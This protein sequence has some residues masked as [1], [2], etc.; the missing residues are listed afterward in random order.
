MSTT[1]TRT[2]VY[3]RVT[4]QIVAELEKGHR[5]WLKP[6]NAE[7]AAG[8]ITRPLRHEGTPYKGINILMLWASAELQGFVS[9]YWLTYRQ[10]QELGGHVKKGEH[11][12]PVVYANTFKKTE[13]AEDARGD[14]ALR[15]R[16]P[17]DRGSVV[18]SA[19]H[20]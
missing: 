20:F 19:Q 3:T 15:L 5:P 6:W 8:R 13:K 12:S 14:Y 18:Q 9:P 11:G 16:S 1:T 10:A 17:A 2:D 7:H 4:S